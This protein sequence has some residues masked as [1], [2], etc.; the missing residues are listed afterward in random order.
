MKTD[1]PQIVGNQDLRRRLCDDVRG[2]TLSHAY[3]LEGP[4][5]SGKHTVARNLAAALS[6]ENRTVGDGILPCGQCPACRKIF[7]GKSPDIISIGRGDKATIGVETV[8]AIREE[9]HTFPN[10][11]DFKL[12]I[13]EDAHTMTQQAQNAFLLTLEEPPSFVRF[14]LLCE[15][16]QTLLETIKSRAP[17]LHTSPVPTQTM[18]EYLCRT[19]PSALSLR[20]SAPREWQEIL[21][22]ADGCIGRVMQ[23]LDPKVRKPIMARRELVREW[24]QAC[25]TN[26]ERGS[27]MIALGNALGSKRDEVSDWFLTLESALRDLMMLKKEENAPLLFYTDREEALALSDRLSASTLM[28]FYEACEDARCAVFI[29]NA[30]IRLTFMDFI[31]KAGMI[32]S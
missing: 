16:T 27:R 12:Y 22:E 7:E 21:S 15:N 5:G 26:R 6:C 3:I 24:I 11:L 1:M 25:L 23:L 29:R 18:A 9:V 8:R 4:A 10:D 32:R 17:V 19:E 31:L 14:L 28:H 2:G 20:D 30:N 13:I